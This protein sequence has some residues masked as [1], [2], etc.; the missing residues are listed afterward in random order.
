MCYSS[1]LFMACP[2]LRNK[3]HSTQSSLNWS[4]SCLSSV[5]TSIEVLTN[6]HYIVECRDMKEWK[7]WLSLSIQP[8]ARQNRFIRLQWRLYRGVCRPSRY[9]ILW[10][11]RAIV[12]GLR[13]TPRR[14]STV[15]MEHLWWGCAWRTIRGTLSNSRRGLAWWK[16]GKVPQPRLAY[17]QFD[18][19]FWYIWMQ[20]YHL[21][22]WLLLLFQELT[23]SSED[24]PHCSFG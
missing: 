17:L 23:L 16:R 6:R 21:R 10:G 5:T 12:Q 18:W 8:I 24:A 1:S 19:K 2:A 7:R 22:G 20:V 3:S 14:S 4:S 9:S 11:G 15:L 13:F